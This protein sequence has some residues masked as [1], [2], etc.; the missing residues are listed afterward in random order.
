MSDQFMVRKTKEGQ[1]TTE[2]EQLLE[3]QNEQLKQRCKVLQKMVY[4]QAIGLA[5]L[6]IEIELLQ[7]AMEEVDER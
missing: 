4:E 3:Q 7:G 2:R 5:N 1:A 6:E